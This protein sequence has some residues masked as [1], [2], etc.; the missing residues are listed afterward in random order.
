[1]LRDC[2][3]R[4][5]LLDLFSVMAR[6]LKRIG[7]PLQHRVDLDHD[8]VVPDSQYFVSRLADKISSAF[9]ALRLVGVLG[10]VELDHELRFQAKEIGDK[11][12]D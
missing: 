1:V 5:I 4:S 6:L 2:P 7:D 10:A 8:L 12:S 9:V 3:T 11:W